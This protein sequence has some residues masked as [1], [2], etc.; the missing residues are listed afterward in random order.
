MVQ[1]CLY[2]FQSWIMPSM[3]PQ[4]VA[5]ETKKETT[6]KVCRSIHLL[7]KALIFFWTMYI[8]TGKYIVKGQNPTAPKIPTTSLKN[9]RSMEM[10]VVEITKPVL[11]TNVKRLA[12]Y[13]PYLG[14][15]LIAAISQC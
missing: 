12:L 7:K 9:G 6:L 11:L 8:S 10:R 15:L 13:S 5:N 1:K 2:D 4:E 14:I 3:D